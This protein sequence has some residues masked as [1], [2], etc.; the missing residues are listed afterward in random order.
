MTIELPADLRDRVIAAAQSARAPGRPVPGEPSISPM[1]AVERSAAAFAATLTQLTAEQW[2]TRVLRDLDAQQLVGHLIGMEHDVQRALYGDARVADVDHVDSTQAAAVSQVGR[3]P[4]DT[5]LEWERAIAHTLLEAAD[6]DPETPIALHGMRLPLR[7]LLVV[8][9]FELW[10]HE[11]DIRLAVGLP[12]SSPGEATLAHMTAL[13]ARMLPRGAVQA[14][15]DVAVDVHLVLTGPGGGT[16]DVRLGDAAESE[17]TLVLDA[18][19][20]CRVVANRLAP[21]DLVLHA[22]GE[23]AGDVL[24]AAAALALD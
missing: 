15:V 22:S 1:E 5:L 6:L 13:A 18:V 8:R 17:V 11:N 9:A 4:R 21:E 2:H 14:G 10:T 12:R 16:W 23:H 3:S 19:D 7:A 20:F 24:A